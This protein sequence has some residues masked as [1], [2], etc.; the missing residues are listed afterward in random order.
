MAVPRVTAGWACALV[1]PVAIAA[2]EEES[3]PPPPSGL[4]PEPGEELLGGDTTVLDETG[5]AFARAARNLSQE[6][7]G[8][9]ALGDHQ[10]NRTWVTAPASAEGTDGLGPL[11]NAT[12]CSACHHKDGRNAPEEDGAPTKSLF[13]RLSVPGT[14]GRGAPLPEPTYGTQLAPFSILGVPAEGTIAVTYEI[15]PGAYV[16]GEP[17]ELRKPTYSVAELGY[18]P[19]DPSAN[20]APR[21]PRQLIGLG[22]LEA[23]SE[24][25][26]LSRVDP[27]DA[28]GDGISGRPNYGWDERAGGRR[29]GRFGWKAALPTIEQQVAT[30]F[31]HDMGISSDIFP[32]QECTAAETEC[33][34][35]PDGGTPEIDA[36]KLEWINFY[37]HTIAVPAR[38]NVA[39]E[40]VL[41]GRE[42]FRDAG[43]ASCHVP[44]IV[45]GDLAGYPE[46]SG[47]TIRPFSDLLLHDMGEALADGRTE[48]DADGREWRTPPLWGMGL[49]QAV[50][51]HQFFLHDGRARGFAEAILWH[52]GEALAAKEAFRAMTKEERAALLAFLESL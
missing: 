17:Y 37:M 43:C 2:C 33:V 39:D 48:H 4:E 36:Q 29:L 41:R 18:G 7:K 44:K 35:A 38:R 15:I 19:L 31:L 32:A 42:L 12:N 46:L 6:Q 13:L 9:F 52:G 21:A 24:A 22:L 25:E 23:I 49:V 51:D 5:N 20:L 11:Y 45:T 28:D 8:T 50:N 34:A 30:A 47:Q 27:D 26:I 16:D 14:D 10:F 40:E 3:A 1:L